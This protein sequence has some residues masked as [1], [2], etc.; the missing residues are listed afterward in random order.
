MNYG[1]IAHAIEQTLELMEQALTDLN[2]NGRL[3][4]ETEATFKAEYAKTK[5]RER[6]KAKV[7]EGY[8]TD[9]ADAECEELRLAY[10]IA[11]ARHAG[12]KSAI[13]VLQSRLDGLRTLA[14]GLRSVT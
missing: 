6:A 1:E 2:E 14:A 7:T 9:V 5:L 13:S 8:L 12:A 10:L 3:A 4:A 11:S